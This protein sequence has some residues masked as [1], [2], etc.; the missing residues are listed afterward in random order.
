M[1][2]TSRFLTQASWG[3]IPNKWLRSLLPEVMTRMSLSPSITLNDCQSWHPPACTTNTPKCPG[4]EMLCRGNKESKS[5]LC[6]L[7]TGRVLWGQ[8]LPYQARAEGITAQHSLITPHLEGIY[9][10]SK[11]SCSL[12]VLCVGPWVRQFMFGHQ[13][14]WV[15]IYW[16][17]H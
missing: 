10:L 8:V 9:C 15:L 7:S 11:N 6:S 16:N 3:L 1:L 14:A 5:W 4:N 13:N 12:P 17:A 2:P